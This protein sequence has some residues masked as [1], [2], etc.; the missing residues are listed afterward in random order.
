MR[1]AIGLVLLIVLGTIPLNASAQ[2]SVPAVDLHCLNIHG[3]VYSNDTAD[4]NSSEESNPSLLAIV[5]P[6]EGNVNITCTVTNPNAYTEKIKLELEYS[7][8]YVDDFPTSIT[9]TSGGQESFNF[10][11]FSETWS[12]L[13]KTTLGITA[14]VVE[15]NGVPPPNVAESYVEGVAWIV[16]EEFM[17]SSNLKITEIGPFKSSK[18]FY[19]IENGTD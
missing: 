15:A 2:A 8:L 6:S 5:Y 14:K 4:V 10:S 17:S 11:V 16:T 1:K 13:G 12:P 18:E 7:M 19:T 3:D 9:L